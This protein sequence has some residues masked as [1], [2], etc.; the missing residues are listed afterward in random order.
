MLLSLMYFHTF[1]TYKQPDYAKAVYWFSMCRDFN[2]AQSECSLSLCWLHLNHNQLDRALVELNGVLQMQ[3]RRREM[4]EYLHQW[5]CTV[6]QHAAN[7]LAIKMSTYGLAQDEAKYFFMMVRRSAPDFNMT[8]AV[9]VNVVC[10]AVV[11]DPPG[12][13]C[14]GGVEDRRRCSPKASLNRWRAANRLF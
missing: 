3:P 13:L 7:L 1:C 9:Y 2:P 6:P 12:A 5:D 8:N 10:D 14:D 4:V 11:D